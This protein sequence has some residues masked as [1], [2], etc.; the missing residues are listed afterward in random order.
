MPLLQAD[1]QMARC[2][3]LS[4]PSC[5]ESRLESKW[6]HKR[7]H[8]NIYMYILMWT[9]SVVIH[10]YITVL[11]K[12]CNTEMHAHIRRMLCESMHCENDVC[13][14]TFMHTFCD[15][16]SLGQPRGHNC[17]VQPGP[18]WYIA[19]CLDTAATKILGNTRTGFANN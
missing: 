4:H 16:A 3:F 11:Y 19:Q 2:P 12:H 10:V 1:V 5:L 18:K 14:I 8:Y 17:L 15:V 6:L 13:R 7:F 9:K